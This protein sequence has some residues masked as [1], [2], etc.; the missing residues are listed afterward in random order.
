MLVCITPH[1]VLTLTVIKFVFILLCSCSSSLF[2][3]LN[4]RRKLHETHSKGDR[5]DGNPIA[6][7]YPVHLIYPI[8]RV[9][10]IYRDYVAGVNT[11]PH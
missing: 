3:G 8:N 6:F 10:T 1:I 11:W 4:R 9:K 2:F 7:A 5:I